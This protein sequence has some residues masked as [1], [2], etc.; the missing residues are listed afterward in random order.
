M[1]HYL[2]AEAGRRKSTTV[3]SRHSSY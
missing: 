2:A 3:C 1:L